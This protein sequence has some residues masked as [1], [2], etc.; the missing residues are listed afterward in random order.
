MSTAD[1]RTVMERMTETDLLPKP[2][3]SKVVSLPAR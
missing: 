1:G 2:E 3:E